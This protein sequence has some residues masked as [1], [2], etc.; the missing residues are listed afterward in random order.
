MFKSNWLPNKNWCHI[1]DNHSCIWCEKMTT[2][3][4]GMWANPSI[5]IIMDKHE[6]W[7]S[8]SVTFQKNTMPFSTEPWWLFMAKICS[9][10][11]LLQ[12]KPTG[13][14]QVAPGAAPEIIVTSLGF[15]TATWA[16][17]LMH[18]ELRFHQQKSPTKQKKQGRLV[19]IFSIYHITDLYLPYLSYNYTT[20]LI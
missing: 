10:G 1:N 7:G 9:N 12:P 18:H 4:F 8:I 11:L 20:L 16:D 3:E 6:K 5:I 19:Y 2:V 17:R 13:S 14:P 15:P